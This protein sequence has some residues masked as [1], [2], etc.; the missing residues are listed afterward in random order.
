MLWALKY[1]GVLTHA[2]TACSV[3]LDFV[4]RIVRLVAFNNV[5][6]TLLLVWMGL[7]KPDRFTQTTHVAAVAHG[8]AC[9]V[10]HTHDIHVYSNFRR[11]AFRGS[12]LRGSKFALS[13]YFGYHTSRD[14]SEIR[15]GVV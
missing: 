5:A 11:N 9:M 2:K 1:Y 13:H 6:S 15:H 12:G 7:K 3:C 8:F 10:G 14:K 4:E